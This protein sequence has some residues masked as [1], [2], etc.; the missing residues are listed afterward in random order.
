MT[1]FV[2]GDLLRAPVEALVN[3]VNT[4][5]VMGK[6]L[7]LAFKQRFPD[8]FHSYAVACKD[9]EVS[10]GRMFVTRNLELV[11]PRLI[12][13]FP[14]K[15]DWRQPSKIEWIESGLADL[16]NVVVA[17]GIRSIAIPR[18]GCGLGGLPWEQVRPLMLAEF[19]AL[20]EIDWVVYEGR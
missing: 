8:S 2:Q 19:E 5:G 14:T 10:V 1:R 16:R 11:G 3:A 13:H 12:I 6:G 15:Q 9:G 7:A 17:N 18:L 20:P 4:V